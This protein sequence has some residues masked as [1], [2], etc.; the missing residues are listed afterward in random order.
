MHDINKKLE[1]E[2]F[3]IFEWFENNYVKANNG[4][5][6]VIGVVSYGIGVVSYGIKQL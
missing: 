2:S 5:L 1:T 3:T 6:Q 4:R